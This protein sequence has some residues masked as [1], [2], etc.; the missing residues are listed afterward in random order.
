MKQIVES[1]DPEKAKQYLA[2]MPIYQ[3]PAI[4]AS[5]AKLA[6]D[7]KQGRWIVTHQ[8]IAFNTKGEMFDGQHRMMAVVLSGQTIQMMVFRDVPEES[9]HATDIG[10]KRDLSAITGISKK[11]V[12]TYRSACDFGFR[13][14]E[15]SFE[16]IQKVQS[17]ILGQSIRD[18]LIYAPTTRRLVTTAHVRLVVAIWKIKSK[19]MYPFDQ[20]RALTLQQYNLMSTASQSLNRQVESSAAG[21]KKITS[22][23]MA[24]RAYRVFDPSASELSK[25]QISDLPALTEKIGMDVREILSA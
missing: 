17:S 10:R 23:D 18:L 5:V 21:T 11:E 24:A 6:K 22:Y 2:T 3:R 16:D 19:S 4:K 7:M 25:I 15:P 1:I 9:W 13:L 20:Y 14:R 12:E 8:G